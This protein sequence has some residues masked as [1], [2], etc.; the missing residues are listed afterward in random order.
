MK[1]TPLQRNFWADDIYDFKLKLLEML[2]TFR[3]LSFKENILIRVI[4]Y[5]KRFWNKIATL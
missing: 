2:G 4:P 3:M 5:H 1:M